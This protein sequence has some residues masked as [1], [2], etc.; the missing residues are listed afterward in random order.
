MLLGHAHGEP[1]LLTRRGGEVFAIGAL[2]THYGAPLADGLLV[3]DTVRCP[4]HHACFSL[5]T[6]VAVRRPAVAPVSCWQVERRDASV[7]VGTKLARVKPQQVSVAPGTPGSVVIVGGGAG[8]AAAETLR[9]QGYSGR[10]TMLSADTS[11]PCDR[12]NLGH[13]EGWDRADID[14]QLDAKT[15]DCTITYRRGGKKLA[16]AVVHRDLEGLRAEVE[17]ERTIAEI[18]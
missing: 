14:G 18:E 5:R 9:L 15:R 2:C 12:P 6:G 8:N 13:A 11:G 3:G 1:V 10:I 4:W 17:F 16:V 7:Y